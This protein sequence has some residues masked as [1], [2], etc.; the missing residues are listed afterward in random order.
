MRKRA[1]FAFAVPGRKIRAKLRLFS[2][3]AHGK[4][5]VLRLKM[6][7]RFKMKKKKPEKKTTSK[8][9]KDNFTHTGNS[10]NARGKK[11]DTHLKSPISTNDK[12]VF[13]TFRGLF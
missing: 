2:S 7:K 12:K 6:K 3:E 4:N 13:I 1:N 11:V 8:C 10:I 9:Q 5:V